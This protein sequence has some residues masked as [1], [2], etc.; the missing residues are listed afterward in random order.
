MKHKIALIISALISSLVL[1]G[2]GLGTSNDYPM[3]GGDSSVSIE[4]MDKGMPYLQGAG[5]V[6][7]QSIIR[8]GDLTLKTGNVEEVFDDVKDL[9]ANLNGRVESSSFVAANDNYGP[10]GY[11]TARIPESRLDEAIAAVSD[12]GERTSLNIYTSDVTLQT[13]DLTA[14]IEALT[15][16]R[17]RLLEL[18]AQ[19]TTT[20]DLI[21]AEQALASRQSELD[22]YQSQLDYLKSQVSESTLNIQIIDDASSVTSG[23]RGIKETLLKAA[24]NFLQ[25]FENIVIFI[26]TVIPW[27]LVIGL[28][29]FIPRKLAKFKRNRSTK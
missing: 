20:A 4:A 16:S 13:I 25:A 5:S 23:L 24:Q 27:I 22:S 3:G 19:A 7:S 28:I 29:F 1:A 26:G 12:L 17:D 14:K 11:I 15:S 2:C 21:A 18:L 9:L 6:S 10:S 8:I